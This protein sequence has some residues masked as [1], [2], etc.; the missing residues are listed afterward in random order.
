[1]HLPPFHNGTPGILAADHAHHRRYRR[2]LAFSFSDKGLRQQRSL[3]ERSVNLLI[4][5]LHE[6]C[7]Q[8]P[9]DLTLW[10]NWATFDIIGD[11]AFGNSF[12]CLD[13]VQTHPW[14]SSIQGNVKLIPILNAFRRYRLDGLLQLLGSRKLLEQRR[15][16]AQF[17]TDQV[18]RRLK[19]SSTPRGDIWD[20]VLAQ[21]PDGE[22]PMSREEMISNA[23]AIV[24]AG[25]ETSATLLSGCTWLLLKNPGHLHQLTSRIRSQFTHA[26]EIDSQSVSRVEGLQAILEESLRLYP[27]VPMQNNRIVPQSGAYIAG[28]W[29]PGGVS[30]VAFLSKPYLYLLASTTDIRRSTTVCRL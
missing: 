21:K 12:G 29:V 2:L 6:N 15:R 24:L 1:M 9:L 25:S 17:T 8:G 11:L 18:D 16:N 5:R 4:T 13:N 3:I 22:P 10:F 20:A 7:G 28:G 14:I 30:L 27:P 19:N 26:S 23:S